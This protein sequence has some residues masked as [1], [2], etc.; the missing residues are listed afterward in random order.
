[1]KHLKIVIFA[2]LFLSLQSYSQNAT[3][4]YYAWNPASPPCDVFA[5]GV[6]VPATVG[7]TTTTIYHGSLYGQ[8]S[9]IHRQPFKL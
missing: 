1:M 4:D 8:P 3:I 2:L 5:G 6:N 9:Y 7:G